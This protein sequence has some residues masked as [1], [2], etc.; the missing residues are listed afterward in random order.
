MPGGVHDCVTTTSPGR[1]QL[2]P[3][4]PLGAQRS[5]HQLRRQ[6]RF[7]KLRSAPRLRAGLVKNRVRFDYTYVYDDAGDRVSETAGGATTSWL[8]NTNNPT[9]YDQPMEEKIGGSLAETYI[10][11]YGVLGQSS[12]GGALLPENGTR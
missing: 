5:A 12:S 3:N 6:L 4:S 10:I 2:T 7:R 9:G 1:R 11:G 8:T